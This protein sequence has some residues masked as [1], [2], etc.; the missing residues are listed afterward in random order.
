VGNA[1]SQSNSIT[2]K[3]DT[4]IPS[5]NLSHNLPPHRNNT[6]NNNDVISVFA[7]FSKSVVPSPLA[8]ISG[9]V[10]NVVMSSANSSGTFWQYTFNS[11]SINLSTNITVVATDT[12]GNYYSN[13]NNS[14]TILKDTSAPTVKSFQMIDNNTLSI[15]FSEAVFSCFNFKYIRYR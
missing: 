10:S 3:V 7:E 13:Q 1:I 4:Q 8:S 11:S 2:L 12:S 5:V 6:A 9:V 15:S 14:I